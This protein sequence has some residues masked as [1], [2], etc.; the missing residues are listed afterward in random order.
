VALEVT[1]TMTIKDHPLAVDPGGR[2]AAA[3]RHRWRE[4]YGWEAGLPFPE[5]MDYAVTEAG[6]AMLAAKAQEGQK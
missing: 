5:D 4:E 6:R 2:A 3:I 1:L